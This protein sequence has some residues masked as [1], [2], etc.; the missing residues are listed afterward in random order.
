MIFFLKQ[1]QINIEKQMAF[2]KKKLR[3]REQMNLVKNKKT[4]KL[5]TIA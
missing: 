1:K 5:I 3:A 2:K 4:K